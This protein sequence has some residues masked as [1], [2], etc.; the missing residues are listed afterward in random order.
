MT[1]YLQS[2]SDGSFGQLRHVS[3]SGIEVQG[4]GRQGHLVVL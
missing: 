3:A 4:H 2:V 1:I